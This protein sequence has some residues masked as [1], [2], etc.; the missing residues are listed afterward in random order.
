MTEEKFYR[1][2]I[3]VEILSNE[4]W[5]DEATELEVVNYQITDGHSIGNVT[6][7]VTNEELTEDEVTAADIRIGGDGTFLTGHLH[8]DEDEEES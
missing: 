6:R 4:P 8:I 1:N 3:Q 2:V 5:G 7:T